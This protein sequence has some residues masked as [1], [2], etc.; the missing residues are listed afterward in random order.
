LICLPDRFIPFSD[1]Q[2]VIPECGLLHRDNELIAR[3]TLFAEAVRK[4]APLT[5]VE[6][7]IQPPV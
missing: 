1:G 6:L 7:A 4:A 2:R 3:A 5:L